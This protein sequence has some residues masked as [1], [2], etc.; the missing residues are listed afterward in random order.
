MSPHS[1]QCPHC[2]AALSYKPGTAQQR[3]D[4]CG[5]DVPLDSIPVQEAE[6]PEQADLREY[7]CDNCGAQIVTD[8]TS[9]AS[10]CYY[11]HSPV[12]LVD[13]LS[14]DFAPDYVL[15]FQIDEAKAKQ[16]FRQWV[17]AKRF[18]EPG[19]VSERQLEKLTGIYLPFW[20]GHAA[21]DVHLKGQGWITKRRRSASMEHIE[22]RIF[23]IE[24]KGQMEISNLFELAYL[25]KDKIDP[26][27]ITSIASYDSEALE[28]FR[29]A[30]LSGFQAERWNLDKEALQPALR[31]RAQDYA[32]AMLH[33]LTE[34]Y[35]RVHFDERRVEGRLDRMEYVLFPAWLMT[36]RHQEKTY[37]FA[38]NAQTGEAFGELPMDQKKLMSWSA[39]LG[40]IILLLVLIGGY[41]L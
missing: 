38:M 23:G 11:C 4:Y 20:R 34:G 5:A 33:D 14:G 37:V 39:I 36:Y 24:R 12:V 6:P 22:E 41:F 7:H 8:P 40:L 18:V 15:P 32:E 29:P 3:C 21:I 27:L 13:R 19:F 2:G 26:A 17:K 1:Y 35:D 31:Q 30:Y 10:Q 9:T 25:K 28:E 16:L